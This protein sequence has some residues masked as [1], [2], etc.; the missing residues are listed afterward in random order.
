MSSQAKQFTVFFDRSTSTISCMN[1]IF[2]STWMTWLPTT[3]PLVNGSNI[4]TFLRVSIVALVKHLKS[5]FSWIILPTSSALWQFIASHSFA[6]NPLSGDLNPLSCILNGSNCL[7][8][9]INFNKSSWHLRHLD[10]P[11]SLGS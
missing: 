9:S 3:I 1:K 4:L 10:L 8:Q 2:G 6:T 7:S 11:I 5:I